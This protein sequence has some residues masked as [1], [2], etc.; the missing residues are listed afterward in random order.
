[1]IWRK[2]SVTIWISLTFTIG[3]VR[4]SRKRSSEST[5]TKRGSNRNGAIS[6][7]FSLTT[8]NCTNK[9]NNDF[10]QTGRKRGCSSW[11]NIKK[12]SMGFWTTSRTFSTIRLATRITTP[13]PNRAVSVPLTTETSKFL[14]AVN[15]LIISTPKTLLQKCSARKKN[16]EKKKKVGGQLWGKKLWRRGVVSRCP[17]E[18]SRRRKN[19]LFRTSKKHFRKRWSKN[20]EKRKRFLV[21]INKKLP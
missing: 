17:R 6:R 7:P 5:R 15:I 11:R 19:R 20:R 13:I 9:A 10:S 2:A 21:K 16:K 14:S 8:E 12:K 4:T 3:W 18:K 1:M